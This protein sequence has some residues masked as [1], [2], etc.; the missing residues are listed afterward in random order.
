MTMMSR[1]FR[2]FFPVII[3]LE[4]GGFKADTDA[5]LELAAVTLQFDERGNLKPAS[6]WHSH[7]EPFEGANIEQESL[8][9]TGIEPHSPLRGAISEQ[10]ALTELFSRIKT[11][12][13]LAECEMSI[14]VAHNAIFDM[15]FLTAAT[16]RSKVKS[17]P[18]HSFTSFD[19]AT[20]SGL[21][22]GQTVLA[23]A[24]QAADIE[25]SASRA[26]SALYDAEK[27]A[28]LFCYIVNRWKSL[29]GWPLGD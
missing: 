3:D 18:F 20:L 6:T 22:L 27:T 15:G 2:G 26:H 29:G 19:T 25:F 9:F 7:I 11:A 16:K 12:Q 17:S 4:T 5:L 10:Q 28:E 8:I 23:R 13:K 21:A 24:C 1:R 14:L